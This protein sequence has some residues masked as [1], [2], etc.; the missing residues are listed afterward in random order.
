MAP[1][2]TP[3]YLTISLRNAAP[4]RELRCKQGKPNASSSW[5]LSPPRAMLGD[6]RRP[7]PTAA[8][9]L[10]SLP[11]HGHTPHPG[12]WWCR[13]Y[14]GARWSRC[15]GCCYASAPPPADSSGPATPHRRLHWSPPYPRLT[16]SPPPPRLTTTPLSRADAKYSPANSLSP[17]A[18]PPLPALS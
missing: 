15:S 10:R 3:W 16:D 12:T 17:P 5:L 4:L 2:G 9:P 14:G 13:R 11:T 6:S 1:R 7:E 18:L 8:N